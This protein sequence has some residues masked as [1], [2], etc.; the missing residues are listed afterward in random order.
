MK[1]RLLGT[2]RRLLILLLV[3]WTVVSLVT[4]LIE[5]VPGDPAVAILGDQATPEQILQFRQKHGLDRP[6]FFFAIAKKPEGGFD[7]RWNGA[8]NRYIDYWRGIL[9]GDMGRSF[10]TDRPV[11][12]L[13]A[14]RYPSTIILA[15]AALLIAIGIA[16]PLGVIAGSNKG[17]VVDSFS[18]VLALV[19]I[20]LPGFVIGPML[21]YLFAIKL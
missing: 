2:L 12:S 4:V 19:G 15:L 10:R 11:V 16:I 13:I 1:H 21:V 7:L 17:T 6:A 20:S 18:S 9:H 14:E 8:D 3:V 5:L